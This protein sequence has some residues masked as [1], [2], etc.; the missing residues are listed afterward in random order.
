[1]KRTSDALEITVGVDTHLDAHVAVAL[2]ERGRVVGDL[3]IPSTLRGYRQLLRWVMAL[4]ELAGVAVEGTGSYG[5]G[6]TRFLHQQE[7]LAMEADRPDRSGRRARG[8]TDTFDAEAAA[9][10]LLARRLRTRPKSADGDV[11][12]CGWRGAVPS[13]RVSRQTRRCAPLS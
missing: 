7:V 6:L 12:A 11:E 1:M 8:K 13:S 9:R 5:A 2:D 10:A 3:A 4:G